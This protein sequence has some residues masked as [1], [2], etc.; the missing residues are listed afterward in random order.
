MYIR[1]QPFTLRLRGRIHR[2]EHPLVAGILNATPDSFY[3]CS[4]THGSLDAL[5]R[6]VEKLVAESADI[7]D[8]GACSTRP[9]STA[10][11]AEEE[12]ERLGQAI[13]V[14]REIAGN[15]I[16]VSVDTYR[17]DVARTV[18]TEMGVDIINDI[19]GGD[20]DSEMFATIAELQMPY[21]L[22]HM[23]GTPATM[24]NMCDYSP[25]GVTGDLITDL[26]AKIERLA[27][28]A[29]NDIIVDP[30]F[31]FA[32]T[33]EQNYELL[34]HLPEIGRVLGR[35]ILVGMSRKSMLTRLLDITP[36]EALNAT[37]VVNTLAI[38]RGAAILRVHDV[39]AAKEAIKITETLQ[40]AK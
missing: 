13:G 3:S 23:R 11:S 36:E 9:G 26:S 12:T 10:V 21:I 38:Q 14:I 24:Q 20:M 40:S 15:G 34:K 2:Y 35:P 33:L 5:R 30:G 6:A 16:P 8:V 28:M 1:M 31:G 17:A 7:I 4:R 37:T 18:V 19:S 39:R 27:Q 25:A 22:M 29:V 32:K